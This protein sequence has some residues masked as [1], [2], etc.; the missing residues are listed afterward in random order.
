MPWRVVRPLL[1]VRPHLTSEHKTSPCVGLLVAGVLSDVT[2][3]LD[4]SSPGLF[5]LN[6]RPS[7]PKV[8]HH[9]QQLKM[10]SLP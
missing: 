6:Q 1:N 3:F 7:Q 9:D 5:E 4:L 10:G 8:S 2:L